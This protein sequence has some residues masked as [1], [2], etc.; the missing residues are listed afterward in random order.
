MI[1]GT[2]YYFKPDAEI[3]DEI[4]FDYETLEQRLRE[5][6]FLNKG[7]KIVL[8]IKEKAR[9]VKKNSIMKVD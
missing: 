1:H 6:A 5:L 8:K 2:K 7:I 4:E 9:K 3:F